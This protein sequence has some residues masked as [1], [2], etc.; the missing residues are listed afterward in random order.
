MLIVDLRRGGSYANL[1]ANKSPSK[2]CR[3]QHTYHIWHTRAACAL[4][5]ESRITCSGYR[6][7][8]YNYIT[9]FTGYAETYNTLLHFDINNDVCLDCG[10]CK[11]TWMFVPHSLRACVRVSART[12]VL[13]RVCGVSRMTLLYIQHIHMEACLVSACAFLLLLIC[14]QESIADCALSSSPL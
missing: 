7:D 9:S 1:P 3:F 6:S 8:K 11:Q 2:T 10:S 14:Y 12:I 13:V 4:R 5:S